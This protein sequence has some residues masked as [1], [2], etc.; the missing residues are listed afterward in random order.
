[1]NISSDIKENLAS[2]VVIVKNAADYAEGTFNNAIASIIDIIKYNIT[3][4]L[5]F[6]LS[7]NI[8]QTGVGIIIASNINKLTIAVTDFVVSPIVNRFTNGEIKD[9]EK[10]TMEVAG[11]EFKVGSLLL[12]II[13]F[14]LTV[15]VVYYIWKLMQLPNFNF[16]NKILDTIKPQKVK[17]VISIPTQ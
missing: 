16:I 10:Y 14:I 4:M 8:I 15:I 1:M 2:G 9:I 13:S 5:T 7:K 12:T 3:D 6:I 17:T 11:V